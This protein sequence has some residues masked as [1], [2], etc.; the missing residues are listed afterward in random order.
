M[1]LSGKSVLWM[2]K[3]LPVIVFLFRDEAEKQIN[4]D[5]KNSEYRLEELQN[6]AK[7][8][9]YRRETQ[10]KEH[11]ASEKDLRAKRWELL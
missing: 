5:I 6:A 8:A 7:N 3:Q 4:W 9:Q 10:L 11:L 1:S 2:S